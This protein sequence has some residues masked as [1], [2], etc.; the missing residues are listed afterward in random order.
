VATL[1]VQRRANRRSSARTA[2][3]RNGNL[4]EVLTAHSPSRW[5]TDQFVTWDE[6]I[7][8]G[9]TMAVGY[10]LRSPD[11]SKIPNANSRSFKMRVTV[12]VGNSDRTLEAAEL[13][14]ENTSNIVT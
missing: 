11:W 5:G 1:S 2:V 12:T 8:P 13:R 4:I 9:Q 6:S 3:D 14:I 10:K 7:V